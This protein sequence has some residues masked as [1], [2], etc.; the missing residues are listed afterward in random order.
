MDSVGIGY[1][2]RDNCFIWVSDPVE[3]QKLLDQQLQ[4]D[5]SSRLDELLSQAHPLHAELGRPLGQRYYWS[6][7]QT[8][9][10]TDLC[11][12]ET[13]SLAYRSF[14]GN[15]FITPSASSSG[16]ALLADVPIG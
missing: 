6:A 2:H 8:E 3:A 11:F 13:A 5:W 14:I 4:T 7:S 10:A 15:F 1:D 9:F 12:K 16:Q